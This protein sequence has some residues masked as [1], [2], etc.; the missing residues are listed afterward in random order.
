MASSRLNALEAEAKTW[1]S[2]ILEEPLDDQR[3]QPQLK[4]GVVLCNLA[5][6]LV[7][8][9]CPKPSLSTNQFAQRENVEAALAAAK[10]IGVPTHDLFRPEDVLEE[11]GRVLNQLLARPDGQVSPYSAASEASTA[12]HTVSDIFNLWM[13]D[14]VKLMDAQSNLVQ[15]YMDL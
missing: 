2:A 3:L 14:P 15:S 13:T 1:I 10:I 11:G 5:N 8:G 6:K 12:V 9:S 4:S 7:P